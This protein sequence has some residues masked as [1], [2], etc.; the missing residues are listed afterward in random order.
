MDQL[1][2]VKTLNDIQQKQIT[3]LYG[4]MDMEEISLLKYQTLSIL[5]QKVDFLSE[6]QN[7]L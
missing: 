4:Q 7:Q 1:Q 3:Y 6:R 2:Q 5:M